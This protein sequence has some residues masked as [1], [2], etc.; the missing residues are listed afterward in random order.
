M[1]ECNTIE[2]L[3]AGLDAL[4]KRVSVLEGDVVVED[5][6]EEVVDLSTEKTQLLTMV[7]A[8]ELKVEEPVQESVDKEPVEEPVEEQTF[9]LCPNCGCEFEEG[10]KFCGACGSPLPQTVSEPQPLVC[11]NCG[12]PLESDCKFCMNC[13]TKVD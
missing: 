9:N 11:K 5:K 2:E 6:T 12:E 10:M 13:G 3:K 1:D 4:E 7:P 8:Q